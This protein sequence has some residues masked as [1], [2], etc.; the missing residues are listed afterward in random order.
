MGEFLDKYGGLLL[1]ATIVLLI[2]IL[3][4]MFYHDNQKVFTFNVVGLTNSTNS[5]IVQIHFE[6][7]KFCINNMEDGTGAQYRCYDECAKLGTIQCG[8]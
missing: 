5:S 3:Q 2:I 7:I 1:L 6:C 4:G 8:D